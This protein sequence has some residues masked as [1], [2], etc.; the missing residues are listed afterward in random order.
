MIPHIFSVIS[1]DLPRYIK[2]DHDRYLR[3][4]ISPFTSIAPF[5]GT[6]TLQV[7][8]LHYITRVNKSRQTLMET[9]LLSEHARAFRIFVGKTG[10]RALGRPEVKV[11]VKVK[12]KLSQCYF[13]LATTP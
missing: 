7:K 4:I 11:K 5:E 8:K 12:E 9:I 13:K 2:I 10:K 6:Q 1:I 3:H